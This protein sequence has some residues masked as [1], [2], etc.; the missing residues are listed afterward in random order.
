MCALNST[1]GRFTRNQRVLLISHAVLPAH[2]L[3]SG[4]LVDFDLVG[5]L[6]DSE[7]LNLRM[8]SGAPLS[9]FLVYFAAE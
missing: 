1:P 2:F 4:T 7:G 9:L 6:V 5:T 3:E 8:P